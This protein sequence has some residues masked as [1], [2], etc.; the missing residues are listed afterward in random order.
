MAISS[1]THKCSARW[2]ACTKSCLP[3]SCT[4]KLAVAP[5]LPACDFAH[6][7]RLDNGEANN[8]MRA[9]SCWGTPRSPMRP[10]RPPSARRNHVHEFWDS[11]SPSSKLMPAPPML[12]RCW[13]KPNPRTSIEAHH[14]PRKAVIR[15]VHNISTLGRRSHLTAPCNN[16]HSGTTRSA[17]HPGARAIGIPT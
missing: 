9:P 15:P 7:G 14:T 13:C 4:T 12:A 5:A 6:D 1:G 10:L 16:S 2:R 17:L 3:S 8:R 11:R